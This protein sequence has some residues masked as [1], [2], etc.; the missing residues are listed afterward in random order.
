[1]SQQN[2]SKKSAGSP[3][4]L[5]AVITCRNYG[6]YLE[7]CLESVLGQS[8]AFSEIVLVDD[9][10]SDNT[11]EIAGKYE[12][13]IG[14]HRVLFSNVAL[15]REY[16]FRQTTGEFIVFIDAD[17]WLR[18]DFT[19]KLLPP[20]LEDPG[21]GMSYCGAEL[22]LEGDYSWFP[23][24]VFRMEP[25][26]YSRLLTYN[27][28]VNCAMVRRKAWLGQDP[29]LPA[30]EDWDHWIRIARAGWTARLVPERL[31]FYRIHA[32]SRSYHDFQ[33][34]PSEHTWLVREKFFEFETTLL[35]ILQG[36]GEREEARARNAM[37][38]ALR[39]RNA[40]VLLVDTSRNPSFYRRLKR[41]GIPVL[42][43]PHLD[44]GWHIESGS[45]LAQRRILEW[46]KSRIQGRYV[47]WFS[48]EPLLPGKIARIFMDHLYCGGEEILVC[49]GSKGNRPA[50]SSPAAILEDDPAIF[51][52]RGRHFM[53]IA[54]RKREGTE[55]PVSAAELIENFAAANHLGPRRLSGRSNPGPE[56]G[57]QFGMRSPAGIL[58]H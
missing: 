30:L 13:R 19:E 50:F 8:L 22:F 24:R 29:L 28:I 36:A 46:V 4:R 2:P 47:L 32:G 9:G 40:Q 38:A 23:A 16:G 39:F 34:N 10:S 6:H 57:L 33:G 20:L 3:P 5:S 52:L 12:E 26:Q 31:F 49:S 37:R 42:C 25:Y 11:S 53:Q 14:Y 27:F 48:G 45:H 43:F 21:I 55:P 7:Q 35:V 18:P 17:D 58:Q 51:L 15:A 56:H 44:P 1:M 54:F 41:L